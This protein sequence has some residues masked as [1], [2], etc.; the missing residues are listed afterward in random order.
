LFEKASMELVELIETT[1][2]NTA[3]TAGIYYSTAPTTAQIQQE[4]DQISDKIRNLFSELYKKFDKMPDK[5]TTRRKTQTEIFKTIAR[6]KD[7]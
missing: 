5:T 7:E 6:L 4:Y 2:P 3:G 1:P